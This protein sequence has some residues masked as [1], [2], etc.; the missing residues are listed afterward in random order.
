MVSP[1]LTLAGVTLDKVQQSKVLT[2]QSYRSID[3]YGNRHHRRRGAGKDH[4]VSKR[5]AWL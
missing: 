3:F 1:H 2:L 4:F 5:H